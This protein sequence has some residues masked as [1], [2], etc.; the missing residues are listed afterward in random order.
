MNSLSVLYKIAVDSR[1]AAWR[2]IASIEQNEKPEGKEQLASHAKE[3]IAKVERELQKIRDGIL[4]LMDKNLIPSASTDE[5]KVLYYKMKSDYYRYLAECATNDAKGKAGEDACVAC[6]EA[7][8]TVETPQL[9][10]LDRVID[11]PVVQV[12]QVPQSH[13]AEKTVEIPQFDAVEKIVETP[14]IQT[15]HGTHDRIQQRNVEG[16]EIETPLPTESASP[17]FVST[18]V[19]QVVEELAETSKVFFQDKVQQR[20]E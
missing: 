18:P 16:I 1:R 10:C 2:V 15:G 20:F 4:A 13:V 12:E 14:V 5:S 6:A 9:Q 17:I 3:Y 19:P 8:K 7:T 11:G